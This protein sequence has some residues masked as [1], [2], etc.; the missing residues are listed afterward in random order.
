M[1]RLIAPYSVKGV[2]NTTIEECVEYL[3]NVDYFSVDT[4]TNGLCPHKNEVIMLQVGTVNR[5]YIIDTRHVSPERLRAVLEGPAKKIGTNIKF[6]YK[7]ILGNFG[8]RMFNLIDISLVESIL[9][10]GHTFQ[11][12]RLSLQGLAKR[13]L[14]IDLPKDVRLEFLSIKDKEFNKRQI[15]YGQYDVIYPIQI[16]SKQE[17]LLEQRDLK[18]VFDLETKF[19]EVVAEMEYNGIYVDQNRWIEIAAQNEIEAKKA[20]DRLTNYLVENKLYDFCNPPDLFSNKITSAINWNSTTQVVRLFKR[21][22]VPTS[23]IDRKKTREYGFDVYKDTVG[24]ID[25]LQYEEKY[26]IVKLYL[27]YKRY[28]KAVNTFGKSWLENYINPVTDRVHTGFKQ[29]LNTGRISSMKPNVQ[30][31]PSYKSKDK[32]SYEAH[33]TAFVAP[34]GKK[35]IVRD[36]SGQELRILADVS[37]EESMIDEFVNG[38]GD[39]HSLT[40]SGVFNTKVSKKENTHLRN[41]GKTI[42]FAIAYGASGAKIAKGIDEPISKGDEIIS[43]FYKTYPAL[44]AYFDEGHKFS[45][46]NGYILIDPVTRRRSYFDFFDRYKEICHIIEEWKERKKYWFELDIP[47]PGPLDKSLWADFFLFKGSME[48]KSQNFRI[49]GLAASMTKLVLVYFLDFIK[50]E[51]LFDKIKIILALH[52][53]IVLEV[54]EDVAEKANEVLQNLM[55]IAG[56]IFCPKVPMVSD[57]GIT[58]VW[59]H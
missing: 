1:V 46:R 47:E 54:D 57:G 13:Y 8:I 18:K 29:I 23:I 44:K 25:M 39:I 19:Q 52:D 30:Q 7:M 6:D 16:F 40:A 56:A 27:E 34:E 32:K 41:K 45:K 36:Y 2:S 20:L 14:D 24:R 42:N 37:N 21:L 28:E 11:K 10:C 33:R 38:S 49:Q 55:I 3:S 35:L 51:S 17:K 5:Q 26:P 22:K 9:Y 43:N 53:E 50:Q 15:Q 59:D 31:I 58:N 12:G 48:R 4:E